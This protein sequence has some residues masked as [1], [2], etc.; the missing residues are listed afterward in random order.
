MVVTGQH[1][2]LWNIDRRNPRAITFLTPYRHLEQ[3]P[4]SGRQDQVRRLKSRNKKGKN[5]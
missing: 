4:T 2:T 3:C 5:S 1:K